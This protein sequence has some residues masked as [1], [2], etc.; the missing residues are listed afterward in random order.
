MYS[1]FFAFT[2]VRCCYLVS[3]LC[4]HA[5][6]FC[7]NSTVLLCFSFRSSFFL[8]T[9]CVG[10]LGCQSPKPNLNPNVACSYLRHTNGEMMEDAFQFGTHG[11]EFRSRAAV[12]LI[13]TSVKS[14]RS[15]AHRTATVLPPN[16]PGSIDY[17]RAQRTRVFSNSSA[18]SL[19]KLFKPYNSFSVP[20]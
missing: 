1:T 14:F 12:K 16:P 3:T 4:L 10:R 5:S 20:S 19:Q 9:E 11:A 13:G 18:S 6:P 17:Y 2:L 15:F 7:I 8:L